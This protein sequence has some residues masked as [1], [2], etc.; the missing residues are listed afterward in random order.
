MVVASTVK[1]KFPGIE[2]KKEEAILWKIRTTGIGENHKAVKLN[3]LL[4]LVQWNL[5]KETT[6]NVAS[7]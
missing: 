6:K 2:I 7:L 4:R 1:R 5:Y 3:F